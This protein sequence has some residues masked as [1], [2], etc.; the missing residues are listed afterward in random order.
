MQ[1]VRSSLMGLCVVVVGCDHASSSPPTTPTPLPSIAAASL[2][3]RW[4]GSY[5]YDRTEPAGCPVIGLTAPSCPTTPV[6]LA[7]TLVQTGTMLSGELTGSIFGGAGANAGPFPLAGRVDS[8][9]TLE[10]TGE[11]PGGDPSCMHATVRRMVS[12]TL[13]RAG[14]TTLEGQFH[15]DGDRRSSSC[16]FFDVQV[17]ARDVRLERSMP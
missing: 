8:E 3:G 14:A 10:L 16:F 7:L 2:Q 12:F 6:P 4:D 1:L 15:F 17:Y 9:S 13:R 5:L 11:Q